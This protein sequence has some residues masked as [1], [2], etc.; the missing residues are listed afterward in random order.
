MAKAAVK[1]Y[2]EKPLPAACPPNDASDASN[3]VVLR[4]VTS[5]PP[6]TDDFRSCQAEGKKKP[7]KCDDCTWCACSVWLSSTKR[8]VIT[9]LTKLANHRNKKF[10]AHV[11]INSA[12]GKTKPHDGDGNHIRFWMYESFDPVSATVKIENV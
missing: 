12:S 7:H 9:G 8:E 10:I 4:L 6:A 2:R 3:S 11:Q 5:N 1:Q